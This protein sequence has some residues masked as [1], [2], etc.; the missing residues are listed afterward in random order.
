MLRR[1]TEAQTKWMQKE[2]EFCAFEFV[3]SE[4]TTVAADISSLPMFIISEAH[5]IRRGM[6]CIRCAC[7]CVCV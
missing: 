3:S 5:V 4:S 2:L 7:V 1:A 6:H